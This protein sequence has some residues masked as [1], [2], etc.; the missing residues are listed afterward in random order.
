M[1]LGLD[2]NECGGVEA[3][4]CFM[5]AALFLERNR[6]A[7][8]FNVLVDLLFALAENAGGGDS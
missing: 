5:R 6:A 2:G 8:Q 7:C 3:M 1:R 4:A